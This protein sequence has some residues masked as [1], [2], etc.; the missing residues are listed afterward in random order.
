MR[1]RYSAPALVLGDGITVLGTIRCLGNAGIP[2]YCLSL[3]SDIET[4]SRWYRLLPKEFGL[5]SDT[6]QLADFLE[7]LLFENAVLIPCTDD[8]AVATA[9]LSD[10]LRERFHISQPRHEIQKSFTDKGRFRTLLE[11]HMIPHPHTYPLENEYS[12]NNLLD[13]LPGGEISHYFLKPRNSLT[14]F[15]HYMTKAFSLKSKEDALQ[16]Y[17]TARE[18]GFEMLLQEFV[19]G[20]PNN[21]FYV[22]GFIDRNE[23]IR[24]VYARQR[25]RMYPPKFGNSSIF[26]SIPASEIEQAVESV[27]RLLGG[28]GYRGIYSA[29]FK[30]DERD[31]VYKLLEVNSRCWWYIEFLERCGVNIPEMAYRDALGLEV[32]DVAHYS[33]GRHAVNLRLDILA[34]LNEIRAG[35]LNV[36][37]W[38]KFWI[39]AKYTVLCLRDPLP[40]FVWLYSNFCKVFLRMIGRR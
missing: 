11:K 14:F 8:W 35:R 40:A 9:G 15:A 38:L 33:L 25:L 17:R 21:H 2:C 10:H 31:G 29:E 7:P 13:Q 23:I 26:V 32:E 1:E 12:L 4:A 16:K 37:R 22:E 30:R 5:V 28:V 3:T 34:G 19:L 18:A 6:G 24:C 36:W 39:G 27:R 20:P